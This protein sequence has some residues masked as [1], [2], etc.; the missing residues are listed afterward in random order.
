MDTCCILYQQGLLSQGV[1]LTCVAGAGTLV[2]AGLG[3][4]GY[5]LICQADPPAGLKFWAC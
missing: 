3:L 1:E 5:T 4:Y 2:N